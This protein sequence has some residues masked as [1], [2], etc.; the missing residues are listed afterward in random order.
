MLTKNE[1]DTCLCKWAEEYHC[2]D[3]IAADPVQFPH[4]YTVKEDIEISGLLTAVLSFGNRIQILK[5]ADE[6]DRIMGHAPL[7]YVLSG[8]W[9]DDF[10]ESDGRSF[11]RMLSYADVRGYFEKLYRVYA[12]GKTL[13]NALKEYKGIPMQQLCSFLGVSDRSPQKKLNM[14]L[15]WM[16]RTGSPVD[17]G[18]WSTMSASQLVIPLDTHVCRVAYQLGLTESAS[19][20]LNNAKKITAALEKVFPGDP[21]LG[22]FALFGYGVNHKE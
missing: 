18:I 20:S 12:A 2:S 13:E 19:F 4:R 3:F 6:L 8:K 17:F 1:L 21:C 14:F 11:Y 22:D 9:R 15:R 5:K 10:P 7:T 16:I